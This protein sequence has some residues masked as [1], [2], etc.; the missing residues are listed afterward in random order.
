MSNLKAGVVG[1][2]IGSVVTALLSPLFEPALKRVGTNV[3]DGVF[4]PA[5]PVRILACA[6]LRDSRTVLSVPTPNGPR[7]IADSPHH[8]RNETFIY[9]ENTSSMPIKNATL[10][11]YP[12][13]F[14]KESPRLSLAI[15][16]VTSIRGSADYKPA[17]NEARNVLEL[18]MPLLNP[19]EA[20]LLVQSYS[21]PVGFIV[22]VGG[23]A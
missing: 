9:V 10:T 5:S 22:E 17:Y 12:L 14:G 8:V 4:P 3:A 13:G 18:G 1:A 19:H 2:L 20:V 16:G 11:A 15:I 23:V 7:V 6:P 21:I